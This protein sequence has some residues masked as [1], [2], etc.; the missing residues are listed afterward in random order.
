MHVYHDHIQN[1]FDF[2]PAVAKKLNEMWGS[3]ILRSAYGRN[4]AKFGMQVYHDHLEILVMVWWFSY[5]WYIFDLAKWIKFG[6]SRN[7][8]EK[9]WKGWPGNGEQRHIFYFYSLL[10]VLSCLS[11]VLVQEVGT[12]P[13]LMSSWIHK[14]LSYI[15]QLKIILLKWATF[16]LGHGEFFFFFFRSISHQQHWNRMRST[17]CH[18]VLVCQ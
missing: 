12:G 6:S 15:I 14:Y 1:W 7:F 3:G 10:W 2:C 5:F 17:C 8:L 11:L 9:S 16:H 13:S 18:C 4:G